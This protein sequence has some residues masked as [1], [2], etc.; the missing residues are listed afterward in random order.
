VTLRSSIA[1]AMKRLFVV[2]ALAAS[3]AAASAAPAASGEVYLEDMTWTEVRDAIGAGRTT[4]IV[5]VGGTEQSGPHLAL[6]KHNVRVHVLAGRIAGELGN[7]LVAPV[8]AYV[9]EGR[10]D[11]PSGHMRF[12]GTIS[13]SDDAFRGVLEGAARSLRQ[14]G[15]RDIVLIGDHGGYQTQ[16]QAV[17]TRLDREWA[18]TPARVHY[19][20]EYYR[21]GEAPYAQALREHG[22]SA[23]QIGTHAGAA[24]T[25]LM[26]AVDPR[27]VRADRLAAA[28]A[29]GDGVAGDPRPSSAALG[30]LGVDLIVAR[31]VAAIR[32]A[33]TR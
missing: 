30:Q 15:F 25:S 2:L 26:L 16:L 24:D 10:I 17:A 32:R 21:A 18:G 9:P 19:V 8:V 28:P 20:A 33:V 31:S 3:F 6:G 1:A 11:V 14:A 27:L 7:A 22:L 13:I 12:P 29:P 4:V 5:P 23:A